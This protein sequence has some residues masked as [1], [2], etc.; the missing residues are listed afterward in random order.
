MSTR[1]AFTLI[2]LIFAMTIFAI[3]FLSIFEVYSDIVETNARL[4][5]LAIL[6]DNT[7]LITESIASEVRE[8]GIDYDYYGHP[9]VSDPIDYSGSGSA[10]LAI[11][12][13]D[14]YYAMRLD[15]TPC[16]QTDMDTPATNCLVGIQSGTGRIRVSD[17][18]VTIRRMRFFI[19]GKGN[20]DITNKDHAGKVTVVFDIG[21]S[22]QA[23]IRSD[24]AR[25]STITVQ[26]TI[27]E[28]PYK[29]N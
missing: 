7:R 17:A 5:M 8:R 4:R 22:T 2:E 25:D 26:T 11:R 29:G 19:S 24:I 27:A 10:V 3:V 1:R 6:Q 15:M 21:V 9:P 12:G 28:K 14:L 18:R 23:G 20:S 16:S 13:G